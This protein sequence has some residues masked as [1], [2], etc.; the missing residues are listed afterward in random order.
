VFEAIV[1][2]LIALSCALLLAQPWLVRHT[3]RAG[4]GRRRLLA[5]ASTFVVGVYTGYFGAASGVL[6][7][8]L[9]GLLSAAT[10]HE[11]NASK[12]LLV[13][14]ANAVATVIF[15][16]V[17][18][19]EWPMAAALAVGA[20]LGGGIGVRLVRRVPGPQ[21][22]TAIALVGLAVAVRLAL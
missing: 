5:Q 10:L 19:V 20:L 8:A 9:V 2:A 11:L 16:V 14:V 22:R 6:F 21:L 7:L 17:A 1:P 12:N 13:G 4:R 3:L 18:P 15:A